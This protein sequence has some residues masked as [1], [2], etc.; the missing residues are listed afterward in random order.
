MAKHGVSVWQWHAIVQ[1]GDDLARVA[2]ALDAITRPLGAWN[3]CDINDHRSPGLRS[4][5]MATPPIAAEIA[6][7]MAA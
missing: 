5:A 1:D 3:R 7:L 4:A 2:G 6:A